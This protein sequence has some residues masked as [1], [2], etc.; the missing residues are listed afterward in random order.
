MSY[1]VIH[2][3]SVNEPRT[4]I[5]PYHESN[6][7]IILEKD[8]FVI[9]GVGKYD[10]YCTTVGDGSMKDQHMCGMQGFGQSIYDECPACNYSSRCRDILEA[11]EKHLEE[12]KLIK[13]DRI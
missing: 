1:L 13:K 6:V 7:T 4:I 9:D 8:K 12:M 2:R 5:M 3:F 10:G 11:A